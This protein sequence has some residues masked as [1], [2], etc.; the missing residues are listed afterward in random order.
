MTREDEFHAMHVCRQAYSVV[1][2]ASFGV[3]T[4]VIGPNGL[5]TSSHL[6]SAQP[7]GFALVEDVASPDSGCRSEVSPRTSSSL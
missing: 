2:T 5:S 7:F 6:R 3:F 1:I 4:T